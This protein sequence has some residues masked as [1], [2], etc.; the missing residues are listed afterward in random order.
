MNP[1]T[2]DSIIEMSA[3]A[4]GTTSEAIRSRLNTQPTTF[5]RHLAAWLMRKYLPGWS[6][7]RIARVLGRDH[8]TVISSV[9]SIQNALDVGDAAMI[10]RVQDADALVKRHEREQ[11]PPPNPFIDRQ[12]DETAARVAE[13]ALA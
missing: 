8:S 7:E 2:A 10:K 6:F 12:I 11:L 5:A 1:L 3:A 9:Q 13:K 4:F